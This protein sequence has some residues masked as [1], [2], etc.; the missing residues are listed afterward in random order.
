MR[1]S[2]SRTRGNVLIYAVLALVAIAAVLSLVL[3]SAHVRTVK[4]ELQSAADSAAR[5]AAQNMQSGTWAAQSAAVAAAAANFADGT[6]VVVD[7]TTDIDFGTWSNGSFTAI[8]GGVQ[9]GTNAVRVRCTRLSA[10]NN[11]VAV[12]FGGFMGLSSCDL[13][14]QSTATGM[15]TA[16]AGFIGYTGVTMKNTTFY[17]GYDSAITTH[18]SR[19]TA[20]SQVRVGS[21]AFINGKNVDEIDG[22]AV[23]GPG[24]TVNGPNVVGTTYQLSSPIPIPTLP[25]WSPGSNPGGIP[26]DYS[27]SSSTTLPG[28]S[29]WFTSLNLDADLTFS[30]PAILYVNGPIDVGGTLAPASGIPMDLTIYQYGTNTFGDSANNGMNLIAQVEGPGS[31]LI[32]K[33]TLNFYGSGIFNSIYSKNAANFFYDYRQGPMNGSNAVATVQ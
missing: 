21:N 18:P 30:A 9:S 27:I 25:T 17:G 32:T 10:R 20:S 4:T 26:Q 19:N 2:A 14:A 6:S 8:S 29:Y 16:M 3:D 13:T 24:A 33:N 12:I 7:P 22:D 28:G 5:A 15:A 11:G 23:L 1:H 31:D